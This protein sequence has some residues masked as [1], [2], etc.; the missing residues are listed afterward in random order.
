M[1]TFG[2]LAKGSIILE[3]IQSK[4]SWT[5][6]DSGRIIYEILTDR[7]WIGGTDSYDGV[8]GWFQI[9]LTE[10]SI[11]S[12]HID[13]D[14]TL[15]FIS[16]KISAINIPCLYIQD[17]TNI[18]AVLNIISTNLISIESGS[19]INSG[20]IKPIQIDT[21][22]ETGL[23][24]KN[25]YINNTENYFANN[26]TNIDLALNFLYEELSDPDLPTDS[27]FGQLL[28]FQVTTINDAIVEIEKYLNN[29][30]ARDISATYLL[31]PESTNVQFVLDALYKYVLE[32]ERLAKLTHNIIDLQGVPNNFG[33][34]NQILQSNGVD[35]FCL[36]DLTASLV[37]TR[38]CLQN[39]TV[40]SALDSI[41]GDIT[42][43]YNS[44][45]LIL[46]DIANLKTQV[47]YILCQI[48]NLWEQ[49]TLLWIA[50]CEIWNEIEKIW[51]QI[52]LLW[53]QID[54]LWDQI[55]LLWQEFKKVWTVINILKATLKKKKIYFTV[56]KCT[57]DWNYGSLKDIADTVNYP[58]M[59]LYCDFT[60]WYND[61]KVN[62]D[63]T[64]GKDFI[65]VPIVQFQ[66]FM[67]PN[68]FQTWGYISSVTG[69]LDFDEPR[70]PVWCSWPP[71]SE[72]NS[73]NDASLDFLEGG[74]LG[75]YPYLL[76]RGGL[77]GNVS[78][79]KIYSPC[80]K[81][82]FQDN[83]WI[84]Y[85]DIGTVAMDN[86]KALRAYSAGSRIDY[87]IY[88]FGFGTSSDAIL[89]IN[90]IFNT[91]TINAAWVEPSISKIMQAGILK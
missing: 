80:A 36:V 40:Q 87:V 43:I 30:Q 41:C 9:G 71:I 26:I 63:P 74:T 76:Y 61:Y 28:G 66:S 2:L 53:E 15:S 46:T 60:S 6:H 48:E 18:Q 20:A 65:V 55:C 47:S 81:P 38:Y 85:I 75:E 91:M 34:I 59:W 79:G 8:N 77:G 11:N 3:K 67:I 22:L 54:L 42:D 14:T 72:P 12:Y 19:T 45:S 44:I 17:K 86:D 62:C 50:I 33:N 68:A 82:Y 69:N 25:I 27:K 13:W 78:D 52:N 4:S 32:I 56:M 90:S 24:A 7:I 21:S 70:K 49:V 39:I 64:V 29:F 73:A 5:K 58:P 16:N 35:G 31:S 37:S 51:I 89:N 84:F 23:T 57:T 1:D 10:K 83:N 88:F